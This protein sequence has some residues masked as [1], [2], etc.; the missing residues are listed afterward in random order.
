[1]LD[2][3]FVDGGRVCVPV[4]GQRLEGVY[5]LYKLQHVYTGCDLGR[6][7]RPS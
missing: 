7:E 1:M 3:S 6:H 4:D 2:N 5:A